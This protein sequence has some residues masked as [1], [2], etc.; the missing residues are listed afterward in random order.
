[1]SEEL[2]KCDVCK[3]E[4]PKSEMQVVTDTQRNDQGN[5]SINIYAACA[6]CTQRSES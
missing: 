2:L 4:F 5:I 1:M 3:F 6:G